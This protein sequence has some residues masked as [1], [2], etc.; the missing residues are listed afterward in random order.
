[1]I[2]IKVTLPLWQNRIGSAIHEARRNLNASEARLEQEENEGEFEIKNAYF[3]WTAAKQTFDLYDNALIP[4]AELAF[5]SDQAS[6]EAGKGDIL[7]LIDSERTLL[8]ARVARLQSLANVFKSFASLE[9]SVG[10]SINES[11]EGFH[12]K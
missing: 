3:Q 9:R 4:Q 7:N 5:R 2:P 8:N 1:M 11:M 12:E 6:Y 10:K